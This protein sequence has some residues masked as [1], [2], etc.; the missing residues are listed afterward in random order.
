[1]SVKAFRKLLEK[2]SGSKSHGP[3]QSGG[4]SL[5][6]NTP[7]AT[8]STHQETFTTN[9]NKLLKPSN[10]NEKDR[11]PNDTPA[12]HTSHHITS[13]SK[14]FGIISELA[15][16]TRH[17]L[18][19]SREAKPHFFDKLPVEL[20]IEITEYL[21][22]S[23][24][25]LL[26]LTCHKAY[27]TLGT[28]AWTRML[29]KDQ[30]TERMNFLEHYS[31]DLQINYVPCHHCR[32]LHLC[33][34]VFKPGRD[35]RIFHLLQLQYSS[36]Q[37]P[38]RQAEDLAYSGNDLDF[39]TI[40]IAM[41]WHRLGKDPNDWLYFLS[42]SPWP[43]YDRE[44]YITSKARK[45]KVVQGTLICCSQRN[46][47]VR[48]GWPLVQ[49][50]STIIDI[51]P[52]STLSIQGDYP[53]SIGRIFASRD[54]VLYVDQHI[55]NSL[56]HS[57]PFCPTEYLVRWPARDTGRTRKKKHSDNIIIVKTWID[58]GEGRTVLDPR[59][60]SHLHRNYTTSD[61]FKDAGIINGPYIRD[62]ARVRSKFRS[63]RD[64]YRGVTESEPEHT[65]SSWEARTLVKAW[66]ERN[67]AHIKRSRS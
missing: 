55:R 53:V 51:C 5:P 15:R 17:R 26:A 33:K 49:A 6:D 19:I 37:T 22:L 35:S 47:L 28:N 50:S 52:H 42:Y 31:K 21:P 2:M 1:M 56:I 63:I 8:D 12:I 43:A 46:I 29:S 44:G 16:S 24:K 41:K 38:C 45:F 67:K 7:N 39:R 3:S 60:W 54:R 61:V 34:T 57:C 32:T 11:N 62:L 40:Q 58:L 9:R 48:S 59:W 66:S 30:L 10:G 36:D 4:E 25:S 13:V 23:S 20:I 65:V 18:K 14:K 64:A 27:N